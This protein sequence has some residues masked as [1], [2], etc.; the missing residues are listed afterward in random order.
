VR[1]R[2]SSVSLLLRLDMALD[3]LR[4]ARSTGYAESLRGTIGTQPIP[5]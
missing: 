1:V 3:K 5:N 2:G 4:E